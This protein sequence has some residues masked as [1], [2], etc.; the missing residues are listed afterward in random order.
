MMK[1]D[2]VATAM[3]YRKIVLL[4]TGMLI[5]FGIFGLWNMSKQEFPTYTIRQGVIV[6]VYP[7]ATAQ[8]VDQQL[9]KP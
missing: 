3:R 9:S 8:Q 6:G 5:L 1:T 7:G 4:I 2:I